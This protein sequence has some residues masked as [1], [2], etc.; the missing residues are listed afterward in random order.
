MC[1]TQLQESLAVAHQA[2]RLRLSY[3]YIYIY[4][5]GVCTCMYMYMYVYIYIYIYVYTCICIIYIY[6][7][8]YIRPM[9]SEPP[10]PT[11]APDN[12]FVKIFS[13]S[14][15][16]IRNTNLLNV[17]DRGRRSLSL[18]LS[19]SLYIYIYICILYIHIYIYTYTIG[20][21]STSAVELG[22][23]IS[24][25]DMSFGR[26]PAVVLQTSARRRASM[27]VFCANR[28]TGRS[29]DAWSNK[30][31][32]EESKKGARKAQKAQESLHDQ[33]SAK[34][35]T[36]DVNRRLPQLLPEEAQ[37]V[38]QVLM[39]III[40]IMIVRVIVVIIIIIAM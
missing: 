27:F 10:T 26:V 8:I 28:M 25:T 7:Y 9:K 5:Y 20:D 30:R 18:S 32:P 35:V 33:S 14:L 39:M 31:T 4:I 13:V 37:H 3:I 6:I 24:A 19:L 21:A 29:I 40:I 1:K 36:H 11:G 17:W 15:V 34:A 16:Y 22:V 2:A 23:P 38:A 12:R